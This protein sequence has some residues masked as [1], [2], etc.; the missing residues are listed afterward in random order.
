MLN[1]CKQRNVNQ[2]RGC[3]ETLAVANANDVIGV[4]V[5]SDVGVD[6]TSK[7]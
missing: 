3:A 6:V 5:E 7:F 4:N 1:F 2:I